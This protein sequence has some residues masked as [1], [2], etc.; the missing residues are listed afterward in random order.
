MDFPL[1]FSSFRI[2]NVTLPNRVVMAP[3]TDGFSNPDGTVTERLIRYYARR[4][5]GGVGLVIVEGAAVDPGGQGWRNH[6]AL[7]DRSHIPGLT[8]LA[9]AI[10]D[11]GAVPFI[12]LMHCGLHSR[13]DLTGVPPVGPS[14]I[15]GVTPDD[16]H[17][18]TTAEADALVE[19][20]ARAA[21]YAREAGFAGV[22][23]HAAHGYLIT[24]FLSPAYNHR[25]D[26]Y[27]GDEDRRFFFL[28]KIIRQSRALVGDDYPLLVRLSV[29]EYEPGGIDTAMS[30]R[31]ASR[32]EALGVDGI[33]CSAGGG[34]KATE[35][36]QMTT[37]CGEATLLPLAAAVR[38]AVKVPV[39]AVGRILTP[40]T[41]E[42]ILAER[43]AD[44]VALGRALLADPDWAA[45]A[46][47]GRVNEII[48]CIGCN[49]C[50]QRRHSPGAFCLVNAETGHEVE[51]VRTKAAA[52]RRVVVLGAGLPGL[53]AARV[54]A[55]RGHHVTVFTEGLPVGG[56]LSLRARVPGNAEL[57]GAV[58]YFTRELNRLGVQ[59]VDGSYARASGSGGQKT[60]AEEEFVLDTRPGVALAGNLPGYGGSVCTHLDILT[61]SCR[62]ATG[63][64]VAVVGNGLLAG[65]TALYLAG[66][67][68]D[69]TLC[70]GKPSDLFRDTHPAIARRLGERLAAY[71]VKVV[72][73]PDQASGNELL[74]GQT[75]LG[76]FDVLVWAIGFSLDQPEPGYVPSGHDVYEAYK[77]RQEV[78]AASQLSQTL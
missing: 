29:E 27:G 63:A 47:D 69:V 56:L 19:A 60:A 73:A 22:E 40:A 11:E 21:M 7:Y 33:H 48:P 18:L 2:S 26:A 62:P 46:R 61:Q 65:E 20:F 37:G 67:G 76:S 25:T 59:I 50:Q 39:I 77:A 74:C 41:A 53:E 49:A 13:P 24:S 14:H 10:K 72:G 4:A 38:A 51:L 1:L 17:V 57:A 68:V 45:K 9:Q 71:G 36:M 8:R 64:K 66:E 30:V 12:Q 75:S 31:F 55:L 58:V 3:M 42:S 35:Y 54:A 28:E 44:L 78:W 6:L 52:P 16:T 70:G 23:I 43:Q 15:P 32:L 34:R 5:A